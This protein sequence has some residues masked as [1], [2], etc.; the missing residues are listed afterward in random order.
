MTIHRGIPRR[1]EH[2]TIRLLQGV[3]NLILDSY[4]ISQWGMSEGLALAA[5][6]W[7]ARIAAGE[8][9]E[10]DMRASIIPVASLT[11]AMIEALLRGV[12]IDLRP[13]AFELLAEESNRV[14]TG[15]PQSVIIQSGIL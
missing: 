7:R 14:L 2:G 10:P 11:S 15:R 4:P 13:A 1:L 9:P 8:I 12:R 5:S 3:P 6:Y